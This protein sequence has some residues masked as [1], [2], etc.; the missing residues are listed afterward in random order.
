MN[1]IQSKYTYQCFFIL[2]TLHLQSKQK[3]KKKLFLKPTRLGV[4]IFFEDDAR[5]PQNLI[6]GKHMVSC[7]QVWRC[8]YNLRNFPNPHRPLFLSSSNRTKRRIT[9]ILN[10]RFFIIASTN[11]FHQLDL[12]ELKGNV[13]V[14]PAFFVLKKVLYIFTAQYYIDFISNET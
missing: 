2:P 14:S 8:G 3:V 5:K 6:I 4:A 12:L 11:C 1:G 13:G 9:C 10:S 7:K